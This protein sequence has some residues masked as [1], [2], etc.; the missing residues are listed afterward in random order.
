MRA[1]DVVL[2]MRAVAKRYPDGGGGEVVA[3]DGV[4]LRVCRGEFVAVTGA[5]GSGK[6]TL[7]AV[8]G[9]M[10][11]PSGGAV[12]VLGVAVCATD[13]AAAD[14]RLRHVGFVFQEY[15][16]ISALTA[17][18]NV[19]LP[20]ELLGTAAREAASRARAALE[21]VGIG[22]LGR[23]FPDQVSGGQRQRI[24]IARSLAS[25]K[26]LLLA[27]EPT[28]ALDSASGDVVIE[29]LRARA[30]RGAAV[31]MVTHD[32]RRAAAADRIVGMADGRVIAP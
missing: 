24:A 4:D 32:P 20:L 10:E 3:L 22:D 28:G 16:L 11:A 21:Q 5:S 15:N 29:A 2:D 6:T 23:R 25:A 7:L 18:E 17:A 9:G 13:D 30:E 19:A 12:E 31:V 26:P 27:D 8:A 14:L 1:D